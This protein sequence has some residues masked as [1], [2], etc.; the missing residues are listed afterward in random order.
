[1]TKFK[2]KKWIKLNH[3]SVDQYSA[4]K[5]IRLKNSVLRSDLS[6]YSDAYIVVKE[7]W[8]LQALIMLTVER[9]I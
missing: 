6:H 1:M 9:E 8:V 3:L 5:N 7:E 2:T 4:K